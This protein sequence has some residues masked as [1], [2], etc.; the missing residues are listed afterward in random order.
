M[1][2]GPR[3][4]YFGDSAASPIPSL[5]VS[6]TMRVDHRATFLCGGSWHDVPGQPNAIVRPESR[7]SPPMSEK[8]RVP[9]VEDA[10]ADRDIVE[11]RRAWKEPCGPHNELEPWSALATP[12]SP[13]DHERTEEKLQQAL[14]DWD[15]TFNSINDLICLLGRDGTILQCNES[16]RKLLNLPNDQLVGRKCYEVMHG[17]GT[18]FERC[19]YRESLISRRRESIE[20]TLNDRCYRVTADPVFDESGQISAPFTSSATS[21]STDVRIWL[22]RSV[23]DSRNCWPISR[24][25]LSMRRPSD[26]TK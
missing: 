18:F 19:P 15:V 24:R 14:K 13:D 20:L 26:S 10:P 23:F 3:L 12:D 22:W 17:S 21:R 4:R 25:R 8:P 11:F 5:L 7:V 16:M 2:R 1:G 6:A 9:V